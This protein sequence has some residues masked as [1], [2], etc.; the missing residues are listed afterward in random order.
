MT[1]T[2][3]I[4]KLQNAANTCIKVASNPNIPID[5][6]TALF[7]AHTEIMMIRNDIHNKEYGVIATNNLIMEEMRNG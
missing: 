3:I 5:E 4:T 7:N 2:Q 1:P 6:Q